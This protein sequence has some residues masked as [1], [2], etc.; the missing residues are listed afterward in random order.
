ME[1]LQMLFLT[2]QKSCLLI[3]HVSQDFFRCFSQDQ[4]THNI[5]V[6]ARKGGLE[7]IV[8]LFGYWQTS[9]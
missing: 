7:L 4:S 2:P 9:T 6:F 3:P 8:L 1:L 5:N